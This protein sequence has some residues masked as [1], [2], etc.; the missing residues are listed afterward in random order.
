MEAFSF[1]VCA[2]QVPCSNTTRAAAPTARLRGHHPQ[3]CRC[4]DNH[5]RASQAS[6]AFLRWTPSRFSGLT[7]HRAKYKTKGRSILLM[8]T[9]MN[10]YIKEKRTRN[11]VAIVLVGIPPPPT[12][13]THT[14]T[15][16]HTQ[17]H[18]TQDYINHLRKCHL[19]TL[20]CVLLIKDWYSLGRRDTRDGELG[21]KSD[22]QGKTEEGLP[23][24]WWREG[25]TTGGGEL[26]MEKNCECSF[27][28]VA[29]E[30][31]LR[32]PRGNSKEA[33][34]PLGSCS[35]NST[36]PTGYAHQSPGHQGK[37]QILSQ[38]VKGWVHDSVFLT[39]SQAMPVLL[40]YRPHFK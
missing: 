35:W 30:V 18:V 3:Q 19:G 16:T 11:F 14:H 15:H 34:L 24:V 25:C 17:K 31:P 28:H 13:H 37:V 33:V 21:D 38:E 27:E 40:T 36:S 22:L 7:V 1:S 5:K 4:R 8:Q 10:V 2:Y 23:W 32:Q 26:D 39:S 20:E 6:L 12:L 29:F 9:W